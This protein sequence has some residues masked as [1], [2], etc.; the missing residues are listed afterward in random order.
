MD[1]ITIKHLPSI[2][3]KREAKLKEVSVGNM[4]EILAILSDIAR[5]QKKADDAGEQVTRLGEVFEK[6]GANREKRKRG[7]K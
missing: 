3:C 1:K 2:L 4:R 5:E 7:K 6:N